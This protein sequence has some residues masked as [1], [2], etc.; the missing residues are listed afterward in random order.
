MLK[1]KAEPT[2][3]DDGNNDNE[4]E[5]LQVKIEG[6]DEIIIKYESSCDGYADVVHQSMKESQMKNNE[7]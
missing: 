2:D 7:E 1:I 6:I 4:N 5:N 3:S